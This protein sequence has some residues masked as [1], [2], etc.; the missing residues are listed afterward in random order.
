M[1]DIGYSSGKNPITTGI[2]YGHETCYWVQSCTCQSNSSIT[3]L[4]WKT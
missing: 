3:L 2:K 4:I 1:P